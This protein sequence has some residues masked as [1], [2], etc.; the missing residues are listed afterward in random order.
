MLVKGAT[1]RN[2]C[3]LQSVIF[4]LIPRT[5]ILSISNEIVPRWIQQ[6]LIND[7]QWCYQ[8]L[9]ASRQQSITGVVFDPVLWRHMASLGHNE[10]NTGYVSILSKNRYMILFRRYNAIHKGW[11]TT[12]IH[13]YIYVYNAHTWFYF[14]DTIQYIRGEIPQQ[15]II[16][17]IYN[18]HTWLYF[19]DT[20]QYIKGDIPQQYTITSIIHIHNYISPIQCST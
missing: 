3:N 5:D 10:L 6:D 17:Y 9:G 8:W 12:A 7:K 20:M 13:N 4:K 15:Y 2:D 11:N 1:E 16:I 14:L 19:V 18:A